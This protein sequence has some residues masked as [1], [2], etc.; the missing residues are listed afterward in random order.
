MRSI[1][2]SVPLHRCLAVCA[3]FAASALRA[4]IGDV[5]EEGPQVPLPAVRVMKP[6]PALS[7]TE[8][9]QTFQLPPG[10]RVELVAAEPLVRDPVAAAFDLEGNLW[11]VEMNNYNTGLIRDLPA[12]AAGAKASAVESCKIIKLESSRHDG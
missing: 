7:P 10:F 8:E 5:P 11:V 12:L 3:L 1:A 9:M 2:T 4:Q 6:A